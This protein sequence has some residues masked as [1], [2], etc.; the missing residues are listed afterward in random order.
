MAEDDASTF[1]FSFQ[2]V[3]DNCG[4]LI[5]GRLM[6]APCFRCRTP[7]QIRGDLD[8]KPMEIPRCDTCRERAKKLLENMSYDESHCRSVS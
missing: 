2:F 7:V 3:Q 5:P 1:I 6:W 8:G 4:E